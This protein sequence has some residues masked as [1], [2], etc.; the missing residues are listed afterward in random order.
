MAEPASVDVEAE[1]DAAVRYR[2]VAMESGQRLDGHAAVRNGGG[3]RIDGAR[4]SS[5]TMRIVAPQC[6]QT[7]VGESVLAEACWRDGATTV[8][9]TCS[10][11]RA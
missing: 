9:M 11:S 8:G 1:Y 7:K 6:G 3:A 5:S 2:S 10:S 4:A